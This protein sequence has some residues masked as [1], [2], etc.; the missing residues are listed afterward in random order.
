MEGQPV[1]A[2]L[3]IDTVD[4]SLIQAIREIDS[5]PSV[6][7]EIVLG[8]DPDTV[9]GSWPAFQLREVT[10]DVQT[11]SGQ[12]LQESFLMEPYP[13]GRMTPSDFPGLA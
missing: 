6:L 12:I 3:I 9:D 7:M 2:S 11:M 5:A 13:A 10:Y 8:S 4:R 1:R